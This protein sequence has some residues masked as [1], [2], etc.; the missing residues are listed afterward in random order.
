MKFEDCASCERRVRGGWRI[1]AGYFYKYIL[2]FAPKRIWTM[3]AYMLGII[4]LK[5]STFYR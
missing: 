5:V 4:L 2:V 1:L 3:I